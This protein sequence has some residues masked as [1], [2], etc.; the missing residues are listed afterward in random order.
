M[1]DRLTFL[2]LDP[3][4]VIA[5]NADLVSW[6]RIGNS[7]KPAD[8]R[9]ALEEDRTLFEHRGQESEI[10]PVV[11][12]VRPMATLGLYLADMAARPSDS[13]KHGAVAHRE[14]RVPQA[15]ARPVA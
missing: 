11:V 5:P 15:S 4:A 2:Q 6:S 13:S 8:L 3:T 7:Y 14:R 10:E 1:I 12:M 9:N